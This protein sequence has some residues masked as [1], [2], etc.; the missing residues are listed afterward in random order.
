MPLGV[1]QAEEMTFTA[2]NSGCDHYVRERKKLTFLFKKWEAHSL[3]ECIHY[4]S[5]YGISRSGQING[6]LM[7]KEASV[8][9]LLQ[10]LC[11]RNIYSSICSS[12]LMQK[13]NRSTKLQKIKHGIFIGISKK[14]CTICLPNIHAARNTLLASIFVPSRQ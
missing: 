2:A 14:V 1:Q 7:Y 4:A 13:H 3:H 5:K 10:V 8:S 9:Y 12:I 11:Q 6:S